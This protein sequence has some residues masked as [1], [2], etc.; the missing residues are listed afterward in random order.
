M[1]LFFKID[2]PNWSERFPE[3]WVKALS[4]ITP[5]LKHTLSVFLD[6]LML[7][8]FETYKE[9]QRITNSY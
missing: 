7:V 5:F 6:S 3:D 1:F 4:V 8:N 9:S 2:L